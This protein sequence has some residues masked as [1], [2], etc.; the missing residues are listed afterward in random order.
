MKK[1]FLTVLGTGG[2]RDCYYSNEN[3]T[4]RSKFIQEAILEL[5]IENLEDVDVKILLTE[6]AKQRNYDND[7]SENL[8]NTLERMNIVPELIIIPEG[9]T[10]DE[11]WNI[12]EKTINSIDNDSDI[13]LDITHSLRNIPIQ[14][15]VA[16]NYLKLF[17]NI[18][19]SGIYYGAFELGEFK[20]DEKNPGEKIKHA[21]ICNLN[22]YYELL[23][24]TN[25]IN[26]F[27]ETGSANEIISLYNQ[28]KRSIYTDPSRKEDI[29]KLNPLNNVIDSLDNFTQCIN[30][31]RGNLFDNPSVHK[32]KTK[33][34][35]SAADSLYTHLNNLNDDNT[36]I[37]LVNLFS[38][39]GEKIRP[40]INKSNFEVGLATV[41][42][43]INYKL[44][45]QGYTALDETIKTF[46]CENL[47]L[48]TN[49]NSHNEIKKH[50]EYIASTALNCITIEDE[51]TWRFDKSLDD[52]E[53][54]SLK[55]IIYIL[56]NNK[57]FVK[58][59]DSIKQR[60]NDINHFGF[61]GDS[62]CKHNALVNNLKE[63]YE[64]FLKIKDDI[65]LS[66]IN[67]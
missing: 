20:D 67:L 47:N 48:H 4:C 52:K 53:C 31:C 55:E 6:T 13:I 65:D 3:G 34:I 66:S 59:V 32:Y 9:K 57:D 30:T 41:N 18:N 21:P 37:P 38:I 63:Y 28:K 56:R 24:W 10:E 23:N 8:K 26:S 14:V 11:L 39:V 16:L 5:I 44:Y 27:V 33:S 22:V 54:H 15:L 35:A 40:F 51:S 43:C 19:L 2:Y 12:F 58:L 25:A 62:T 7:D 64:T 46:I 42:W 1:T 36:I 49:G 61:K 60:R 50:R 17:K 45:Q 29:K